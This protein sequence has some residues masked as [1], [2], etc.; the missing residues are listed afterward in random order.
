MK[1]KF[2]RSKILWIN[3]KFSLID[4]VS[5]NKKKKEGIGSEKSLSHW[6]DVNHQIH[7]SLL[8]RQHEKKGS[9]IYST[10]L[11]RHISHLLS[12]GFYVQK[13]FIKFSLN[14]LRRNKIA[15]V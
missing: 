2:S 10:W 4:K 1:W 5:Q 12:T 9:K 11:L 13:D 3:K 6:V 14:S 8:Q 15:K 7:Y